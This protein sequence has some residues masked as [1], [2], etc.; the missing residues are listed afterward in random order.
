MMQNKFEMTDR[1]SIG[2]KLKDIAFARV[3]KITESYKTGIL[4]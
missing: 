2:S 4:D 3:L 1:R